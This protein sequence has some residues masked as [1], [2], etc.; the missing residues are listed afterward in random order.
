MLRRW[1]ELRIAMQHT[2]PP[3]TTAS[4]SCADAC[5]DPVDAQS[6][7]WTEAQQDAQI[8]AQVGAQ[9]DGHMGAQADGLMDAQTDGQTDAQTDGHADAQTDGHT[10]AQTDGHTGAQ[11][12]GH[13]DAQTEAQ[14]GAQTDEHMGAPANAHTVE[15]KAVQTGPETD[16]QTGTHTDAQTSG[17]SSAAEERTHL[18]PSLQSSNVTR[19]GSSLKAKIATETDDTSTA[20]PR[21]LVA[22][23]DMLTAAN[24]PS[25][26]VPSQS[27]EAESHMHTAQPHPGPG[28]KQQGGVGTQMLDTAFQMHGSVS[29]AVMQVETSTYADCKQLGGS[30]A[31]MQQW[32]VLRSCDVFAQWIRKPEHLEAFLLNS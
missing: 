8:E 5:L 24:S 28:H 6:D 12:D 21:G 19:Q 29:A 25:V 20:V 9:T 30:A 15:Q 18:L 31:Y 23:I 2:A 7:A 32:R 27:V 14:A 3:Q 11:T 4:T 10:S 16:A 22:H 1:N 26:N 13:T 17:E